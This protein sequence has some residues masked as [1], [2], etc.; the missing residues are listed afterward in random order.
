MNVERRI[1]EFGPR[2]WVE[3]RRS[4]LTLFRDAAGCYSHSRTAPASA[5]HSMA[6]SL[7]SP[8]VLDLLATCLSFDL[9]VSEGFSP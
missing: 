1:V 5:M 9:D 3:Q 8:W 4:Y 6:S 7:C 2:P